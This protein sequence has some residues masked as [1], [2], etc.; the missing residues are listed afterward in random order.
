MVLVLAGGAALADDDSDVFQPDGPG[1]PGSEAP[2]TPVKPAKPKGRPASPPPLIVG[3]WAIEAEGNPT[4][5]KTTIK[6]ASSGG[7]LSGTT[8]FGGKLDSFQVSGRSF[9]Y[10]D[11]YTDVLGN[12]VTVRWIGDISADGDSATA[13]IEGSWQNGCTAKF[14][15]LSGG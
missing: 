3:N 9:S 2:T 4:C 7:R 11:H 13:R 10:A 5:G 1:T 12:A 14:T 8:S 6:V 15:R